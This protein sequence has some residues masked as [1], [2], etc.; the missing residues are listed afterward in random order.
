MPFKFLADR[1]QDILR[2]LFNWAPSSL[3]RIFVG[4]ALMCFCA[5]SRNDP[6]VFLNGGVHG[7]FCP[8]S[9]SLWSFLTLS[10]F[11]VG[12]LI[13]GALGAIIFP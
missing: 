12:F 2:G 13:S 7:S 6:H 5:G 1:L 9:R 11:P 10:F 3:A 4:L 8:V